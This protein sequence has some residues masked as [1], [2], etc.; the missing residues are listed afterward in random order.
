MELTKNFEPTAIDAKWY[1]H[2][3]DKGYFNSTP[4]SREA[5]TVVIPP[6]NVTG[7]LHM[8]HCLNNTIQDILVRRARM[9][10]KNA[11]WVPGTDHA[12]IATE[13]KVVAMLRERSI[14]KS[15]LT[16]EEFLSYAWEW[17]EKYGGIILQQLKKLGCSLDWN[18]T[19]FTMDEAYYK[20]VI[21]VFIDLYGK[22]LIYR[23]K[24]MVNWDPVSQTALSDEEV[25]FKDVDSNYIMLA[26]RW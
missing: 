7:V 17:K 14:T 8:G 21:K 4:D 6:P 9:E 16:R 25:I 24:R 19:S 23:G 20:A 3:L 22:G 5:Y 12:S 11:C 18:R 13:A 26:T 2:S 1:Q 15:S 10:G